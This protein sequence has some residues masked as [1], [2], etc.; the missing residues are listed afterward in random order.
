M[1]IKLNIIN[2]HDLKRYYEANR[3]LLLIDVRELTEWNEIHIPWAQHIPKSELLQNIHRI[4][5]NL[6]TPIYLHCRSGVR[7]QDAG[8][9]LIKSGYQHVYSLAGGIMDWISAHYEYVKS[10]QNLPA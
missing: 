1:P 4:C 7:S 3:E 6:E 8:Q 2:V 10:E 5:P 9:A